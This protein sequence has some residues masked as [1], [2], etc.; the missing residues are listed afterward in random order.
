MLQMR[1]SEGPTTFSCTHLVDMLIPRSSQAREFHRQTG[2]QYLAGLWKS[3]F[4]RALLWR[5]SGVDHDDYLHHFIRRRPKDWRAPSWSWASWDG[6]VN[7]SL[8][9]FSIRVSYARDA[10]FL[11]VQVTPEA[12]NAMERLKGG[13]MKARGLC[14][15]VGLGRRG[16]AASWLTYDDTSLDIYGPCALLDQGS[17]PDQHGRAPPKTGTLFQ[18]LQIGT[19]NDHHESSEF[20]RQK[21]DTIYCLLLLRNPRG[22][23]YQRVG[24]AY[25]RNNEDADTIIPWELK[26]LTVE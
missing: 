19:W 22:L 1:H 11:D 9:M 8:A 21:D 2:D 17:E 4:H 7:P 3:D 25:L 26:E 20:Y 23:S 18:C 13:L 16:F 14:A 15:T 24:V 5:P 6:P 10:C 12:K